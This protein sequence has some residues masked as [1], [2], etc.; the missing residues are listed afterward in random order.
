MA[1]VLVVDDDPDVLNLVTTQLRQAGHQVNGVG[2]PSEALDLIGSR[3]AP[4]VAVLDINMPEMNGLELL[5][6]IRERHEP[7]LPAVFLS[8]KVTPEDIAAGKAMG[9]TYLTKP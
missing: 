9:A 7:N 4:D 6:A 8:A 2:S 3:G 1:K 5:K